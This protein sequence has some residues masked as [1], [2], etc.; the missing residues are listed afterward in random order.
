MRDGKSVG[1]GDVASASIDEMVELMAGRRASNLYARS[2]RE[3]KDVVLTVEGVGERLE[4]RRGEVVGIGGLVGAGRTELLR[5]I[6]GLDAPK[7][8]TIRV[9]GALGWR[10]APARLAQGVAMSSEDRKAEG[11]ATALTVAANVTLSRSRG[12]FVTK[13]NDEDDAAPWIEKLGIRA[14]PSQVVAELSGG[15]Q[16]KVALARVLHHG[17]DVL[18]VDEPTRGVDVEAKAQIYALVDRAAREGKAV[19]LVSSYWPELLGV[20]D[21]VHVMRRGELGPSHPASEVDEHAL[22][23]EAV[24]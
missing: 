24:Q 16:Q 9:K 21:R 10:S 8:G 11:L 20:C 4:L 1:D 17:A 19:L 5:A 2:P 12:W 13:K 14:R 22:L 18:L 7:R 3:P 23:R 15:N 6:F